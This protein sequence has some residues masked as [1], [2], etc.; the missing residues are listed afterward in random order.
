MI[1]TAQLYDDR[2]TPLYPIGTV[3][4]MLGVSV[5]TLRMYEREGLL[6]AHKSASNQRR[7]SKADIERLECIRR[8]ITEQK[9]SIPAI[10]TIYAM[11]PCWDLAGCSAKDRSS[12]PAY[13]GHSQP[14]WSYEHKNTLCSKLECRSCRVYQETIDCGAIKESIVS[15]G[16]QS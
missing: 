11:I 14:C 7:Y 13:H 9:F 15:L 10:R 1:A 6:I 3:A 5:F 16:I 2:N 4:R 12:C 8:A